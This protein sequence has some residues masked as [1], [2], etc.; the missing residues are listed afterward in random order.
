MTYNII[1][2]QPDLQADWNRF[3]KESANGTFLHQRN[4]MDY[5]QDRFNDFS[6][7]IYSKNKLTA[8]LPAHIID[9][10]IFSH[11]GLTYGEILY[12]KKCH[13]A[14]KLEITEQLIKFLQDNNIKRWFVK[15]IPNIFHR[16]PDDTNL[17]IYP[18][19]VSEMQW[20]K[21]FFVIFTPSFKSINRNRKRSIASTN[22]LSLKISQ[23]LKYLPDFWKII[24]QNLADRHH[25]TPVH[26]LS[27]MQ[28][29]IDHFPKKIRF[30][31]CLSHNQVLAGAIVYKFANSVHFQ[32]IHANNE[33]DKR[34]A[35][36]FL[37]NYLIE[38][39]KDKYTFISFGSAEKNNFIDQGLSY[40][41]E[42][43]GATVINQYAYKITINT[44][45][46]L[47]QILQ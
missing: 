19:L 33:Q 20:V 7:M 36:D 32:Y 8:V 23:D 35:V 37:T 30:F 18:H 5:H 4:Y 24:Q 3:I 21:P 6:L 40:W 46:K 26:N 2:Y 47:N 34:N 29:L 13:L 11:N 39:Y 17:Y 28:L 1:K 22:H 25:A 31:A 14:D 9:N 45:H 44:N 43:F 27:E 16:N 42:S 38:H 12:H 41:K 15:S 10:D